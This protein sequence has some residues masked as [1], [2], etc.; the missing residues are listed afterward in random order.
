MSGGIRIAFC[1]LIDYRV[2]AHRDAVRKARILHRDISL[3]NLLVIIWDGTQAEDRLEFL[4]QLPEKTR[5][6]LRQ[7]IKA[8]VSHRG[9]L[10]D[11][12][13]A[14]PIELPSELPATRPSTP[15]SDHGEDVV[16]VLLRDG[17]HDTKEFVSVAKLQHNHEI[18]LQM[19]RDPLDFTRSSIDNNPLCRT[20]GSLSFGTH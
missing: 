14:V 5:D 15:S 3:L 8:S 2:L 13:Y 7:R 12:G 9:L 20:V 18:K 4:D 17:Q 19:A 11:W 10:A 16:P 6:H 1:S